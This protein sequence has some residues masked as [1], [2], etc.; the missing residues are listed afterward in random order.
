MSPTFTPD[1]KYVVAN[2]GNDLFMY[3][4]DGG[5]GLRLTGTDSGGRGA[6]AAGGGRGGAAPNEFIGAAV[7]A[8]GR[9]VYFMRNS[10]GGASCQTRRPSTGRSPCSI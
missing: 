5:S 6:A 7:S 2:K 1:G 9:F 10:T 4:V 8:T 3:Y